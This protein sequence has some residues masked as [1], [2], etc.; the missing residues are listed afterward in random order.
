VERVCVKDF[1]AQEASHAHSFGGQ[2]AVPAVAKG[3][4]L[5]ERFKEEVAVVHLGR[6]PL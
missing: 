2:A 3:E 6:G 1:T 5:A 4:E